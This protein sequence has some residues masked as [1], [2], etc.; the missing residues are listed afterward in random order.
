[1]I[2]QSPE[3]RRHAH[4]QLFAFAHGDRCGCG[5]PDYRFCTC[6]DR[7]L[8]GF[9]CAKTGALVSVTWRRECEHVRELLDEEG[10]A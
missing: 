3:V 8:L 10:E 6:D 9:H 1:M 2:P 5:E 4:R 7:A